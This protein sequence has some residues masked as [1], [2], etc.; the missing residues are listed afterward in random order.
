VGGPEVIGAAG[1]R[2]VLLPRAARDE[3]FLALSALDF[4]GYGGRH[5]DMLMQGNAI[6]RHLSAFIFSCAERMARD[7]PYF[8]G[9]ICPAQPKK[10]DIFT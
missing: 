5:D 10:Y 3:R 8:L 4:F 2:T 6:A 9:S 1:R 7:L